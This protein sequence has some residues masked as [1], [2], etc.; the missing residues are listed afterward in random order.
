MNVEKAC[1]TST[2]ASTAVS[3]FSKNLVVGAEELSFAQKS[4][5]IAATVPTIASEAIIFVVD[6][7]FYK[8]VYLIS[9]CCL[10]L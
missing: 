3:V 1:C 4:T 6:F 5:A 9:V 2:G 7:I 8:L 10:V